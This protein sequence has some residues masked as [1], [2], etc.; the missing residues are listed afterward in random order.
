LKR[1]DLIRLIVKA[2]CTLLRHGGRHDIYVNP[3]TGRKAPVPRHREIP[4]TLVKI[5]LK[6]LDVKH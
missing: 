3:E 1:T 5:I 6:Q 4:T 2:G